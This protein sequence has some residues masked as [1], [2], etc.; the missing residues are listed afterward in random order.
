MLLFC[1]VLF[2]FLLFYFI[3]V[4]RAGSTCLFA[5]KCCRKGIIDDILRNI[6]GLLR[7]TDCASMTCELHLHGW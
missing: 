2:S 5:L 7:C 6:C 1:F 4:P 3:C